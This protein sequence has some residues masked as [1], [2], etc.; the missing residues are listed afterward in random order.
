LIPK[1]DPATEGRGAAYRWVVLGAYAALCIATQLLWLSFSPILSL[2]ETT[3]GA[4]TASAGLLSAIY[5]LVFAAIS[6]P[7][8]YVVDTF[9]FRRALII[10]G[11]LLAASGLL[12]PF[13][14]DF[15]VLLAFQALG[16]AGQP[17]IYNSVSKLAL[18]WF[19]QAQVG[20]ATGLGTISINAG[21]LL[22]LL[23][24]RS[25]VSAV[26]IHE[27]LLVYGLAA[28]CAWIT[29]L[30]LGR[31]PRK[32][33]PTVERTTPRTILGLL[34][35]R[36]IALVSALLFIGIG[37]SNSIATWIQPMLQA[38][39]IPATLIGP[40]G[41][42]L[43][44]G[45]IVGMVVLPEV[46][47]RLHRIRPLLIATL[48]VAALLWFPAGALRGIDTEALVLVLLGFFFVP[49]IPL[50][51]EISAIAAPANPGEANAI[52]WEFAQIGGFLVT[53]LFE[54]FGSAIG[55]TSTFYLSGIL[56]LLGVALA[57]ALKS[58]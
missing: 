44:F 28:A 57:Y 56:T 7:V 11:A 49:L 27:G 4:S 48:V 37:I 3:Y 35:R 8:G 46:S 20:L 41:A 54:G 17:F 30:V 58:R 40:L 43:I 1:P 25:L 33:V 50:G 19:P 36:N 38:R 26:G 22:A 31:E 29:F 9:G 34:R 53:F 6:I 42:L 47:D 23:L 52:V 18:A 45:G 55:W 39:A 14:P 24:T 12:R 15:A 32:T 13:S 21:T 5:P 16:A 51:L 2:T 10:G